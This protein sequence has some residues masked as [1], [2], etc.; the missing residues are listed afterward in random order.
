MK[1]LKLTTLAH[2]QLFFERLS[3]PKNQQNGGLNGVSGS[4]KSLKIQTLGISKKQPSPETA[5]CL[6]L[7]SRGGVDQL[8]FFIKNHNNPRN[9]PYGAPGLKNDRPGLKNDR[10]GL[11]NDRKFDHFADKN[12]D[13]CSQA[14]KEIRAN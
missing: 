12:Q 2:F 13:S 11:K 8:L 7:H 14:N 4:S 6:F 5:K 9:R 3:A 1:P 10:P